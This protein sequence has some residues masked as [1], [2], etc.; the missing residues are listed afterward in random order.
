M[1]SVI[2]HSV[3]TAVQIKDGRKISNAAVLPAPARRAITVV[4]RS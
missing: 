1:Y 2:P 3:E 4:G